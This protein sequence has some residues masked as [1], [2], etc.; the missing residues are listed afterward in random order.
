MPTIRCYWS[1]SITQSWKG[2]TTDIWPHIHLPGASGHCSV[3]HGRIR[4]TA[5]EQVHKV[6]METRMLQLRVIYG[7]L[8]GLSHSIK[9][10]LFCFTVCQYIPITYLFWRVLWSAAWSEFGF[11]SPRMVVTSQKSNLCVAFLQYMFGACSHLPQPLS[12]LLASVL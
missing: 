9:P 12:S 11:K 7:E 8:S 1:D 2:K 5:R 10:N 4:N 6:V 3:A